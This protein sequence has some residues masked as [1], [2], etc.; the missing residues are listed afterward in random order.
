MLKERSKNGIS[1]VC[2]TY[3]SSAFIQR[4]IDSILSQTEPPTEII[5][6][7]DESHDDTINVI[8]NNRIF[9]DEKNILLQII[10]NK[11]GGPGEARNKGIAKASQPWIAF[12]DSDDVWLKDKLYKIDRAICENPASNC[13]LHW[14]KYVRMNGNITHLKHGPGKLNKPEV[15]L[16]IQLYKKNFLSTSAVVCSKNLI[17]VSG[18]FDASLPNAQD[19]ELWLKMAP[20]MQLTIIPEILGEYIE[21]TNSITAQP[22]YKRFWSEIRIAF[23]YLEYV[24]MRLFLN[25]IFRI[26]VSKQWYYTLTNLLISGQKH[27]N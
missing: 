27:S 5:F 19:Y 15:S 14:E 9:F 2:P 8:E 16:F 23:R 17:E 7:D 25:K 1:V 26:I 10:K 4:T 13:F 21:E 20:N 3:N 18:G 11:H 6:S 24:P 12:L 22:Y